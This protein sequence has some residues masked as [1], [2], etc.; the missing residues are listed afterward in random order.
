MTLYATTLKRVVY[1]KWTQAGKLLSWNVKTLQWRFFW[2]KA[3]PW[4]IKEILYLPCKGY[5]KTSQPAWPTETWN[6]ND[7]CYTNN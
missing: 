6:N 7:L 4:E 1:K 3:N 2:I 5:F